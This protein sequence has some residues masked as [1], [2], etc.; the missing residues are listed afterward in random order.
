MAQFGFLRE[1]S[2]LSFAVFAVK[3]F[4][5]EKFKLIHYA[6]FVCPLLLSEAL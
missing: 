5:L 4:D 1:L 2:G 6:K 3:F